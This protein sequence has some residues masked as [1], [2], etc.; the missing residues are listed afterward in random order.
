MGLEI[1]IGVPSRSGRDGKRLKVEGVGRE[2]PAREKF[3]VPMAIDARPADAG[4]PNSS[5]PFGVP[6]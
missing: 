3:P 4:T 5:A 6:P 2:N 1:L